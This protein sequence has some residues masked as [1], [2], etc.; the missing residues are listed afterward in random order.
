LSELLQTHC[1][2]NQAVL[3]GLR[4]L[5]GCGSRSSSFSSESGI[6]VSRASLA[7][8]VVV[9]RETHPLLLGNRCRFLSPLQAVPSQRQ[10][11]LELVGD[12][13]EGEWLA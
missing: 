3:S 1:K 7:R 12:G 13:S 2:T 11:Q 5:F 8:L 10:E 6:T 9:G 4:G